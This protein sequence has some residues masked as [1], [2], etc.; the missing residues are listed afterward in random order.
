MCRFNK[1]AVVSVHKVLQK[2]IEPSDS[3]GNSLQV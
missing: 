3:T 1:P 2:G